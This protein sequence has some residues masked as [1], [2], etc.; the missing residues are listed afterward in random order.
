LLQKQI[1]K[2]YLNTLLKIP[3]HAAAKLVQIYHEAAL[4]QSAWAGADYEAQPVRGTSV[5]AA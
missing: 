3:L 2:A 4:Q 5:R 1:L